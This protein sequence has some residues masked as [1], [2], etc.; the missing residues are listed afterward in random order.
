MKVKLGYHCWYS[1][2]GMPLSKMKEDNPNPI[3][4]LADISHIISKTLSKCAQLL[5]AA[6]KETDNLVV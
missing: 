3:T 2:C 4:V 6:E 5:K 1:E